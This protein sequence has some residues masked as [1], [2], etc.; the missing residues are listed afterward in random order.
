MIL[1]A[2]DV[3]RI[4]AYQIQTIDMTG[5][6]TMDEGIVCGDIMEVLIMSLLG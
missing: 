1:T 4:D 6:V 2:F 5:Y 3:I